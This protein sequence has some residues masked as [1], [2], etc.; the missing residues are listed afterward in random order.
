VLHEATQSLFGT[1]VF[2][3][4]EFVNAPKIRKHSNNPADIATNGCFKY[5][6]NLNEVK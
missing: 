6:R 5:R 2:F 3:G 4:L 1:D